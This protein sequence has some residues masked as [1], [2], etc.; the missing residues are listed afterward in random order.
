MDTDSK[1]KWISLESITIKCKPN[2]VEKYP[3][4]DYSI[5]RSER[6]KQRRYRNGKSN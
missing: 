3:D 6:R 2:Y 1:E 4:R 5:N